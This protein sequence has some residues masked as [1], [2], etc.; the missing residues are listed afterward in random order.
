MGEVGGAGF[1]DWIWLE[2]AARGEGRARRGPSDGIGRGA[3]ALTAGWAKVGAD[4]L[5]HR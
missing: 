2:A 4:A 5:I 1:R 3:A